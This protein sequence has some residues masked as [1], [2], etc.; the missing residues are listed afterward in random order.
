MVEHYN[1]T[2]YIP[3][4]L[5]PGFL[6][7]CSCVLQGKAALQPTHTGITLHQLNPIGKKL[8]K[9]QLSVSLALNLFPV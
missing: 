2:D 7:G 8:H 5:R 3:S 6:K 4:W 9:M 1:Y